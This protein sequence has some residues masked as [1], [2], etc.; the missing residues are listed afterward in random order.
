MSI[1]LPQTNANSTGSIGFRLAIP[2]TVSGKA[3]NLAYTTLFW[4]R[5]PKMN[6]DFPHNPTILCKGG[7]A[8][9]GSDGQIT[10]NQAIT[11]V[12][13]TIRNST[14]V[15]FTDTAPVDKDRTYLVMLICN[16]TQ[17]HLV[18]C[19]PGGTA[20]VHSQVNNAAFLTNMATNRTW[21]GI[22]GGSS[23]T[24]RP[25]YGEVENLCMWTGAFPETAGIPDTALI[26]GIAGGVQDLDTVH[27][28]LA[29]GLRKFRYPLLNETDLADAW[30]GESLLAVNEDRTAGRVAYPCGPLRPVPLVPAR[31]ADCISQVVF[32][33]PGDPA[34]ARAD[35][36][37]EGGSYSGLPAVARVQARLVNESQAV[38]HDWIDLAATAPSAGAGTWAASAGFAAVPMQASYLRCDFRALDSG[39]AVIAGP[40]PGYG[41]RGAGFHILGQAQ[42]QL[43]QLVTA[44][45]PLAVTQG[46]RA[47]ATVQDGNEFVAGDPLIGELDKPAT[48]YITRSYMIGSAT[49]GGRGVRHGIRAMFNEVNAIHPGV[50]VQ[51]SNVALGGTGLAAY[52]D[53]AAPGTPG[54]LAG[55]WAGLRTGLGVVQ[56]FFLLLLGHSSGPADTEGKLARVVAWSQ[57]HFGT[58]IRYLHASVPRYRAAGTGSNFTATANSRNGARAWCD[59]NPAMNLWLGSW[60]TVF[61]TLVAGAEGAVS[62]PHS[63]LGSPF[64]Q[65]RTGALIGLGLLMA[66]RAVPDVPI[67]ITRV[68]AD[69]ADALIAFGAA[70]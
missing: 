61:T 64:G 38:V 50:P 30:G 18:L 70:G 45:A 22:G 31:T 32:A 66:A 59:A 26:A 33:T 35:I 37:V 68:R 12:T 39:G 65:G 58:P 21:S 47:I 60:S 51:Y 54:E 1:R 53:Y 44:G 2:T 63:D 11:T 17:T 43:A 62:D 23:G 4:F 3:A 55:R 67:G 34:T 29:G 57:L 28:L 14:G 36:R 16:A 41:L 48:P 46:T 5:T 9:G 27:A 40:V 25:Y 52:S 42:S 20:D 15:I 24:N 13:V 49:D 6:H 56:P 8:T 69:G 10:I 19:E 7:G